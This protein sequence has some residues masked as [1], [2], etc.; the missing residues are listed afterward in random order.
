MK[1]EEAQPKLLHANADHKLSHNSISQPEEVS[2]T[3]TP[4][5]SSKYGESSFP[6]N[7]RILQQSAKL[8]FFLPFGLGELPKI[9]VNK[10]C[11]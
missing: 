4:Q 7:F 6:L 10:K 2:T 11:F 9:S 3:E 1:T 5:N 8:V